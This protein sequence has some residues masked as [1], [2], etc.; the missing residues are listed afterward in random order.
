MRKTFHI[1]GNIK[2][3]KVALRSP[4][5]DERRERVHA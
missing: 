2:K 3:K 1:I 4:F 5:L